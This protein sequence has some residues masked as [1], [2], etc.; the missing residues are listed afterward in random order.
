ML[1]LLAGICV[2]LI[3]SISTFAAASGLPTYEGMWFGSIDGPSDPEEFSWEVIL[4]EDQELELIDDQHAAVYYTGEGH[5]QAFGIT[6]VPAHDAEGSTVLT[7]LAV[8]EG[9]VITLT[10]HHRAGNPAAGGAPFV[11]PV[12]VG[13]GWEGGFHTEFV[14]GP[15]DEQEIREVRELTA[16]E[17][18]EALERE[19]AKEK[20][21]GGC[22]VPRL[23]GK[24][25]KASKKM[26]RDAECLIGNVRKLKG[27]TGETGK[28]V[29][30]S[31]KPGTLLTPW[32]TVSV[33]LGG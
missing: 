10:V 15:P 25:L 2:S 8:S 6:A 12:E 9:N 32:T 27:A 22:L 4:G 13:Q 14:I 5:H 33:T 30:Q 26:L 29:K 11:Y 17:D 18:R 16:R 23:K 20:P 21:Q 1:A 3:A 19:W 7:S 31:F 28:I 24:S